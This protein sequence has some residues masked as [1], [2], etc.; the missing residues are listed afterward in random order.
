LFETQQFFTLNLSEIDDIQMK[1]WMRKRVVIMLLIFSNALTFNAMSVVRDIGQSDPKAHVYK[2]NSSGVEE[3]SVFF[4]EEKLRAFLDK[5]KDIAFDKI[6]NII[7]QNNFRLVEVERMNENITRYL[8]IFS[9]Q[10]KGAIGCAVQRSL[11]PRINSKFM[12]T[13]VLIFDGAKW[14]YT[15]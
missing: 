15:L 12:P 11:I 2:W 6:S 13:I 8:F 4:N 7:I 10:K 3:C 14:K 5:K 1:W 9:W